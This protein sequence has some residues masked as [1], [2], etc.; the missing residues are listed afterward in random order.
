MDDRPTSRSRPPRPAARRPLSP[1]LVAAVPIALAAV[2]VAT[3]GVGAAIAQSARQ[4]GPG[5]AVVMSQADAE[6]WRGRSVVAR[7]G[8]LVGRVAAVTL[9]ADGR[10]AGI[11]VRPTG[12]PG[13]EGNFAARA[14]AF[15][16]RDG[17]VILE[18]TGA[19]AEARAKAPR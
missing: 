8:Q 7:D 5:E 18:M 17:R 10:I 4:E 2:L 3:V 19:E 13:A 11:S 16:V 14:E 6:S 1:G 9:E 12:L 15:E